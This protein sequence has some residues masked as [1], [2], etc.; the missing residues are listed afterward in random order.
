MSKRLSG[1]NACSKAFADYRSVSSIAILGGHV[2]ADRSNRRDRSILLPLALRPV[3]PDTPSP[4]VPI[5]LGCDE[6][7]KCD[8]HFEFFEQRAHGLCERKLGLF[9]DRQTRWRNPASNIKTELLRVTEF[10]QS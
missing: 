6:K 5:V 7:L 9:F 1:A 8:E 3:L 2:C 10:E 4:E